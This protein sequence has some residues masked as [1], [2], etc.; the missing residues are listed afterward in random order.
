MSKINHKLYLHQW[1]NCYKF[2]KWNQMRKILSI[3][4]ALLG[5][6]IQDY[7]QDWT[8]KSLIIARIKVKKNFSLMMNGNNYVRNWSNLSK[9]II[10]LKEMQ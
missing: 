5:S 9:K 1:E 6:M 3:W 7:V 10:K 8:L 4:K 2:K